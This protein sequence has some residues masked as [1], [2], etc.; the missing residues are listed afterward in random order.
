MERLPVRGGEYMGVR[1]YV[2]GDG[3]VG[4]RNSLEIFGDVRD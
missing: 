1:E 2:L 4:T 3:E